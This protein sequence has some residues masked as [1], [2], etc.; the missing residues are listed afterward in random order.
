MSLRAWVGWALSHLPHRHVPLRRY[1]PLGWGY[2]C[3]FCL[4]VAPT[5]VEF[6]GGA[7]E[8]GWLDMRGRK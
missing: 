4:T 7:N 8:D 6:Y 5:E 2:V 3:N 1:T